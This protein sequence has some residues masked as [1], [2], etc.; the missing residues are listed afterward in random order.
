MIFAEPASA[1]LLPA[2]RAVALSVVIPLYNEHESLPLICGRIAEVL[3]TGPEP[4][5]S[6]YELLLID[7]GSSDTSFQVASVIQRAKRPK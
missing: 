6:S 3:A 5:R 7:D 1:Q 4:Y 2:M